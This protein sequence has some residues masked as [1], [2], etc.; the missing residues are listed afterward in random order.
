MGRLTTLFAILLLLGAF[1]LI[2]CNDSTK[3]TRAGVPW[4]NDDPGV[5]PPGPGNDT[6]APDVSAGITA[7]IGTPNAGDTITLSINATDDSGLTLTFE[8]SDNGAGGTFTGTGNS[9]TWMIADAGVYVISVKVS[10]LAGNFGFAVFPIEVL[11]DVTPPDVG[12]GISADIESPAPGEDVTFTVDVTGETG[13]VTY[14]WSDNGGGGTFTGTGAE[15]TYSNATAGT[16]VITLT[17]EDE[18]GNI[19][20]TSMVIVVL[21]PNAPPTWGDFVLD[22]D[23]SAPVTTQDVK[24]FTDG[25]ATDADGDGITYTWD[26]GGG[27]LAPDANTPAGEVTS[28]WSHDT[29]GTYTVTVTADDGNGGTAALT[30]D[31]TVTDMPTTFDYVGADTCMACHTD[32]AAWADT[33]HA[34]AI[35]RNLSDPTNAH[36]FRNESCYNCHSVGRYPVGTGGFISMDTTPQFGNIQC[37][38]CHAGGNPAG[39][40]AGHKPLP[41]DPATGYLWNETLGEWELDP[42]YDG[43]AGYGCGLCHE[44]SRHGAFEEWAESVHGTF[45]LTEFEDDGT[46]VAGPPGEPNCVKCH[47]GQYYVAIQIR[48]DAAPTEN[49]P[50]EDMVP[51]MHITCATCHDPHNDQFEAQLRVDSTVPQI[52]PMG[53]VPVD[54]GKGNICI[55]CHNGRRTLTDRDNSMAGTTSRGF[56]GNSQGTML[57]GIGAWE[58]P[59]YEYDKDHPHATWNADS[60]VTCHMYMRDYIDSDN[61]K[62]WG[63]KFEPQFITC[64]GCHTNQDEASMVPYMEDFQAD[65]LALVVQYEEAWPA[66]WK[67]VNTEDPPIPAGEPG[68]WVL[69]MRDADPSDG[70][71]P[72]RD[73]PAV[74][75]LYRQSWWNY[76]YIST[77][78]SLGVHNPTYAKVTLESAIGALEDLNAINFP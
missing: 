76:R 20:V 56:H 2:A 36:A 64:L 31:V 32:L 9:V 41:W 18:A 75:N 19:S 28:Y 55:S 16:Y 54:G 42:A 67:K 27:T 8:W 5:N 68:Y 53:D 70:S 6:V 73:D 46:E 59:G 39:M 43:S 17:V 47:N 50:I 61:P 63:H 33:N 7:S 23:V 29:A 26:G 74:G 34:D 48:G 12:G 49:L 11:G 25:E 15:V 52:I 24:F 66:V 30:F 21:P 71:G 58:Y 69:T 4:T 78:V 57:F 40:G 45:A 35:E 3:L 72:P 65:I 22:S 38:S 37:E 13:T 62:L 1:S 51:G 10:D 14:D 60:C 44:G 77:E